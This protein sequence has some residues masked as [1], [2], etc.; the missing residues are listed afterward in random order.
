MNHDMLLVLWKPPTDGAPPVEIFI[1]LH[2]PPCLF[3]SI[4]LHV[5]VE[6]VHQENQPRTRSVVDDLV[7][8][9]VIYDCPLPLLPGC[10]LIPNSYSKIPFLGNHEPQVSPESS[11]GWPSM[12]RDLGTWSKICQMLLPN[13]EKFPSLLTWRYQ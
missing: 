5:W 6:E 7:L 1:L 9:T 10:R 13:S 2:V 11:V 3:H 4:T 8:K 12:G